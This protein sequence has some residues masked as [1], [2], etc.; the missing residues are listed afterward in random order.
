MRKA[1]KKFVSYVLHLVRSR[2]RDEHLESDHSLRPATVFPY[3]S[4]EILIYT[5]PSVGTSSTRRYG[6]RSVSSP[7]CKTD[8]ERLPPPCV[9]GTPCPVPLDYNYKTTILSMVQSGNLLPLT[10]REGGPSHLVRLVFVLHWTRLNNGPGVV[11]AR[12]VPYQSGRS[13]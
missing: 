11:G 7:L 5:S 3:S 1:S 6:P 8:S 12:W 13:S 2:T 10:R 4:N 9:G